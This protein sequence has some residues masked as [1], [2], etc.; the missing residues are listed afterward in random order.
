MVKFCSTGYWHQ[1]YAPC[2]EGRADNTRQ[3][4][5]RSLALPTDKH[6]TAKVIERKDLS[7]DLWLIRVDPGGPFSFK[8]GQYATLGVDHE[9]Q[10]IERAYS[11]VS[12]PYEEGALEFFIELVPQGALTPHLYKLQVGDTLLCRKISKGRFTLDLKSG[13][14]NHLL[15]STVTGIAPFVSYVRTLYRDW[16]SGTSPMPGNHRFFC[17]QGGSRS[18]EFGYREELERIAAEVPWF[19]FVATISRPWEDASWKGETGR[20]DDLVR[21]YIDQWGLKPTD[22][23]GY[24]CGHPSMCEN[25]QGILSRAGWQK[26]SIFEE[27]Y[28]IP[29]KEAGA[30]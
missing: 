28:F 3:R 19:K 21:K 16:N 12:S 5:K 6:L 18:W 1:R 26:G 27:V 15:L 24:L 8:A 7:E 14:T 17:L 2:W 9:G 10:R 25:G 22:T 4:R 29:G 23:T 13:R 11:I 20:V 30:A